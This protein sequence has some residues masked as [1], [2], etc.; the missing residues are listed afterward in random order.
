LGAATVLILYLADLAAQFVN[1]LNFAD[2]P[3][4]SQNIANGIREMGLTVHYNSTLFVG[5]IRAEDI[6]YFVF[7]I[8]ASLFITTRIVETRR[9]R[10]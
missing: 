6:L 4:I 3:E 10:A 8:I 7:L 1:S 9:W 2:A 5:V